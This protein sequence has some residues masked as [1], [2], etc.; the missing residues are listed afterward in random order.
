MAKSPRRTA[1][2]MAAQ[3]TLKA[4]ADGKPG[5]LVKRNA[6]QDDLYRFLESH[7]YSW[8]SQSSEWAKFKKPKS[9]VSTG[10]VDI[11]LRAPLGDVERA[12]K[13]IGEALQGAGCNFLRLS[14]PD[15][16]DRD[17]PAVTARVY[18]QIILPKGGD[19]A[20]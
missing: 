10:V 14:P 20:N 18:M 17:G 5:A 12:T 1:K 13:V 3:E 4:L 2:Y 6:T 8:K 19:H 16:D 7:G 9:A 15:L 11:R